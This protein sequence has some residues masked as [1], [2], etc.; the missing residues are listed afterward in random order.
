MAQDIESAAREERIEGAGG[1]EI[2]T[3]SWQPRTAPRA[4]VVICHGVNSHGGQY[5]WVE[6][7]FPRIP[8]PVFIL[9]G[10]V[11]KATMP[12]G[13]QFFYSTV[14]S[15]DK[16]L[17]LYEG[18][19]HDLLSDVGKEGVMADIVGWIDERLRAA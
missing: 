16:T 13:S 5:L 15:T 1:L 18:H 2:F 8:L 6:K 14:G 3:R 17:K 10:T 11:D 4:V 19:Y 7:E 9:H 12:R